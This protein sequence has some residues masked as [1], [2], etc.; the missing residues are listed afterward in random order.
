MS[1]SC[2]SYSMAE[3]LASGRVARRTRRAASKTSSA[4][5]VH[6]TCALAAALL[7]PVRAETFTMVATTGDAADAA[8]TFGLSRLGPLP[9]L[10]RLV[11]RS[12]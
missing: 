2:T 10:L 6:R 4:R 7:H 11:S 3:E 12:F 9:R 1:M 5:H 8:T